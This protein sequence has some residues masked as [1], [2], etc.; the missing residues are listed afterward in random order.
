MK[1]Y[2]WLLLVVVLIIPV[3]VF[4]VESKEG[5]VRCLLLHPLKVRI[6]YTHSVSLTKV[7]DTYRVSKDGIWAIEERW[8]QFD[9]GQPLNFQGIKN[10][11]FIKKLNMYMGKSWRYWFIPINDVSIRVEK[12]VVLSHMKKQG[13]LEFKVDRVPLIMV[14]FGRC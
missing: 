12:K 4:E 5:V 1:K 8:Q 13:I 9:A 7:I 10:G 14:L 2:L 6:S 11:Y 3:N